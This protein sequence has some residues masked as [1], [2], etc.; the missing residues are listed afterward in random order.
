MNME[1][2]GLV[3]LVLSGGVALIALLAAVHLLLPVPVEKTRLRLEAGLGRAFLLG[4]VNLLFFGAV[5]FLLVWLAG[6]IRD[7]WSGLAAFLSVLLGL[8]AL[9]ILLCLVVFAVNGLSALAALL[10]ERIGKAKTPF[11]SDLRGGLLLVLAC[12]TPYLGWFG[13][14]PFV[15]SLG[16][17]ATALALFQKKAAPPAKR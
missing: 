6:L 11:Q 3:L 5:A 2:L 17:G 1:M 9:V 14:T 16:L 13:F 15:L 4:I 12:L 8:V 10:G 7:S